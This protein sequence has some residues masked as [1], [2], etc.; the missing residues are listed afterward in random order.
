MKTDLHIHSRTGSD[1]AMDIEEVVK[2]A[3]GR[4][5]A[6]MSVTDHDSIEGQEQAIS[7]AKKLGIAYVT[8]VELNVT[9]SVSSTKSI[10]LDFLG[11]GYDIHNK[12]L[13]AALRVIAGHRQKRAR[14]ILDKIN[15]EFDRDGLDRLTGEDMESIS[16]SVDGAFGRPH[17]ADYLVAKGIV[18]DRQEAFD[19][20]LVKCDVPKYPLSLAEASRLIRNAG[21]ILVLAHPDDPRGTSLRKVSLSLDEQADIIRRHMLAYIDGIECWHSRHNQTATA[22]Y[23]EFAGRN[24][25]IASGGSDCHQK[26]VLMGTLD[27][28]EYVTRKFH[29]LAR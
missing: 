20:Y 7:L 1:G 27:I 10:S 24:N 3:A 28:P 29:E 19:R 11:Y 13:N 4:D 6:L 16:S 25:L 5:I 14:L 2:E 18:H 12:E 26:P 9:F 22:Y 21:G 15:E 23:A 8:G 17:I